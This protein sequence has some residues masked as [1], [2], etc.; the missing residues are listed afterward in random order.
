MYWKHRFTVLGLLYT[1][2]GLCYLDRM[3]MASALPFI[4]KDLHLSPLAA[5]QVLSAFFVGYAISQIPG[6]LMADR[7]GPRPMITGTILWWSFMTGLTALAPG[8]LALLLTRVLFGLGEG[9]FPPAAYKTMA[10]WVPRAALGRASGL[11]QAATA[12]G[13]TVAPLFVASAVLE[14]GWRSSFYLLIVPGIA[15]ACLMWRYVRNSPQESGRVSPR[16]MAD[17]E[18]TSVQ[19]P[20]VK[21]SLATILRTPAVAWCAISFFLANT[22]AW[23]LMNWLPTYLLGSRGFSVQ[24]MG[25]Y[26]AIANLAG[27][28]GYM[29]GGYLCDR[30]FRNRLKVP[31]IAGLLLSTAFTYLA[32]IAP[33][34]VYAVICLV[35]VFLFSNVVATALST[36]PLVIVPKQAVGAAFGLV[37]TAGQLSGILSPLV[38]G[39]ILTETHGRFEIVLYGMVALTAIAVYPAWQ[40]RQPAAPVLLA[41]ES[42]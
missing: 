2:S 40:I 1:A 36:V 11:Q 39:W 34:G 26:A 24:K 25:A 14:W 41:A 17:Y 9:P 35:P 20:Q 12:V 33:D 4:A 10:T 8:L 15:L 30:Y 22:V 16:E 32:A 21:T 3:V 31:I 37:N 6:G 38:V 27:V 28:V 42:A 7:F 18:A 23:G 5:G 19:S 29:L 13:A